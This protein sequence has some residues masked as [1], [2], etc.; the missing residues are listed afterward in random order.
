MGLW[1]IIE[2]CGVVVPPILLTA[3]IVA[4]VKAFKNKKSTK[5]KAL[6]ILAMIIT[7][8]ASLQL[9]YLMIVLIGFGLLGWTIPF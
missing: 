6:L 1:D 8:I 4:L 5:T 2:L 9:V 7:G 3:S